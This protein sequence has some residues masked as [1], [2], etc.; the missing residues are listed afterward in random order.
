[1]RAF[2]P[3]AGAMRRYYERFDPSNKPLMSAHLL[4]LGFRDVE[5][6]TQLAEA[7]PDVQA[8]LDHIKQYLRY[9]HLRWMI[10]QASDKQQQKQL[11]LAI[12][13]HAYRT[14]YSYMN[15]WEAIRQ[16]WIPQAAKDL[17]EPS[18]TDYASAAGPPW[19]V[20][21]PVTAEQTAADFREGLAYFQ[22]DTVQQ[23]HYSEE[24]V[25]V[26]FDRLEDEAAAIESNQSY[27]GGVPYRLFSF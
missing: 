22:P 25:P 20:E 12:F 1:D 14:R 3:A 6:A 4:A 19:A 17:D 18:W 5:E 13:Q 23:Q 9:V 26:S 16:A 27:Q 11:T 2:G 8:R 24:L 15:H 21:E 7:R 10:D